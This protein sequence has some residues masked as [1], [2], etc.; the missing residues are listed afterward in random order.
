MIASPSNPH[1]TLVTGGAKCGKSR[2]ALALCNS[3]PGEKIFLATATAEDEEMSLRIQRHRE[4]R[5][6]HWRTVEE[7]LDP[8]GAL[9]TWSGAHSVV[10]LDCITLWLSNLFMKYGPVREPVS[11]EIKNLTNFLA[12]CQGTVVVVSNEVGM[13]IVPGDPLSRLYRDL[14][15]EANQKIAAVSG[16]VMVLFSGI[17][18]VIKTMGNH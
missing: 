11:R 15:G 14:A 9:Q 3:L 2:H 4:E 7:P 16:T 10:L 1:V 8:A 6:K 18:L 13:G 17:P 12:R 5:G